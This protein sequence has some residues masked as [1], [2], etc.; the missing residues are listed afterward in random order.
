ML[1]H[2][3]CHYDWVL[4]VHVNAMDSGILLPFTLVYPNPDRTAVGYFGF[5]KILLM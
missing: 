5:T 2:E 3:A 1:L 4:W